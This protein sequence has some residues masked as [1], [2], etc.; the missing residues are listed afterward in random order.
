MTAMPNTK[1][2]T[3]L[4]AHCEDATSITVN[5]K[6]GPKNTAQGCMCNTSQQPAM[7]QPLRQGACIFSL[8]FS[9]FPSLTGVVP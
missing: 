3:I 1:R 6:N 8:I 2:P 5:E 4:L 7:P 9:A